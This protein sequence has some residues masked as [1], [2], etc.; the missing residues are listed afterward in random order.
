MSGGEPGFIGPAAD[1]G[2]ARG[3]LVVTAAWMY[4]AVASRTIAIN[5]IF[6][7]AKPDLAFF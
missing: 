2:P 4:V 7:A 1:F 3:L 6:D 5:R